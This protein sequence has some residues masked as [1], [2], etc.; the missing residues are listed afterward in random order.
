MARITKF[1]KL[2]YEI[3]GSIAIL[4]FNRPDK[5]NAIDS[6]LIDE[7]DSAL[8]LAEQ[9]EQIRVIILK[10]AGR[11]FSAGFDLNIENATEDGDIEFWRH[12][13]KRDFDIIMRFWDCP[14][15]SCRWWRGATER[16]SSSGRARRSAR[17]SIPACALQSGLAGRRSSRGIPDRRLTADRPS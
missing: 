14:Q 16:S 6:C 13:L 5:L 8:D 9:D 17:A 11:A 15:Q 12:E 10:G 2:L 4:T 3:D 7:L 1:K